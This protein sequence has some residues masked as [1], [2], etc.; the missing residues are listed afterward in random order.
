MLTPGQQEDA[1]RYLDAVIRD[2]PAAADAA[3][4]RFL[5]ARALELAGEGEQARALLDKLAD[6]E[7]R[8]T[9]ARAT[10]ARTLA[11]LENGGLTRGEAIERLDGLR[12]AWR[13]D[14]FEMSL[15]RRLR[16]AKLNDGDERGGLEALHQARWNFSHDPPH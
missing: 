4:A 13:G 8:P 9:R 3:A 6:G 15:L 11:D 2:A 7:D 14:D 16:E 5:S 1:G 10:L 12:F